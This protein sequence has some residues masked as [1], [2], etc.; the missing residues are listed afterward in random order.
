MRRAVRTALAWGDTSVWHDFAQ[1]VLTLSD[2]ASTVCLS[3]AGQGALTE[4]WVF[5]SHQCAFL[6]P[7]DAI[8]NIVESVD[9][10]ARIQA[11]GRSSWRFRCEMLCAE[12]RT[13][14][15]TTQGTFVH[16]DQESFSRPRAIPAA[17]ADAMRASIDEDGR[18]DAG[19]AFLHTLGVHVAERQGQGGAV[20][21]EELPSDILVR[22]TDADRLGHVNNAKW[23]FF[24]AEALATAGPTAATQPRALSIDYLSQAK[25]G[26]R[27]TCHRWVSTDG[28]S[29]HLSFRVRGGDLVALVTLLHGCGNSAS[30]FRGSRL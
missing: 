4:A 12:T 3:K 16:V 19:D 28:N 21:Q 26:D 24:V 20:A 13:C 6:V 23:A 8:H 25:P 15:A 22:V 2:G 14:L 29:T 5:R 1:R 11:V 18:G 10:V 27:L 7:L 30:T 9:T 17:L